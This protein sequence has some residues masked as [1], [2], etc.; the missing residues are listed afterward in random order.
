[1]YSTHHISLQNGNLDLVTVKRSLVRDGIEWLVGNLCEATG[2]YMCYSVYSPVAKWAQ[3]KEVETGRL[4][5]TM[6]QA[7]TLSQP[8]EDGSYWFD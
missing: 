6:E 3:S 7:K 8:D 2:H 5:V 4:A 1:M